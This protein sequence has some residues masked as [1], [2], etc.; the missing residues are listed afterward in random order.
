MLFLVEDVHLKMYTCN[1]ENVSKFK[2][3]YEN[4]R[5]YVCLCLYVRTNVHENY[6]IVVLLCGKCSVRTYTC[7]LVD[8]SKLLVVCCICG[9]RCGCDGETMNVNMRLLTCDM[10]ANMNANM[11]VNVDLEWKVI[12]HVNQ[13]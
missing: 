11:S 6:C 10:N 8:V 2:C 7:F 12:V 9:C 1:S 13:C 5:I 4:L 3:T